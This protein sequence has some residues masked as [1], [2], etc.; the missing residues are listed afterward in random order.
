MRHTIEESINCSVDLLKFYNLPF[1]D[2]DTIIEF[3][4]LLDILIFFFFEFSLHMLHL[5]L[6]IFLIVQKILYYQRKAVAFK[7]HMIEQ[8]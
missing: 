6:D 3:Y 7:F 4:N 1:K 5:L 8:C 2:F